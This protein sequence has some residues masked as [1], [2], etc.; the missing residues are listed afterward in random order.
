MCT[1]NYS[2]AQ[3]PLMQWYT[4]DEGLPSS[5]V[6]QLLQDREGFIWCCTGNGIARFD[7]TSF[8]SFTTANGFPDRGAYHMRE[9]KRGRI[10]FIAF[11]GKICY[12]ESGKFHSPVIPLVKNDFVRWMEE[13]PDGRLLFLTHNGN[14]IMQWPDGHFR[15]YPVHSQALFHGRLLSP[16]SLIIASD[17]YF[18]LHLPTGKVTKLDI[19][20]QP[21]RRFIRVLPFT[22]QKVLL[23][24]DNG[25]Y[26]YGHES[27]SFI[28]LSK[29]TMPEPICGLVNDNDDLWIGTYGGALR[30]AGG[31][32]DTTNM[33]YILPGRG[34]TSVIRD[35][36]GNLWFSVY[37]EG[38]C[39]LPRQFTSVYNRENGLMSDRSILRVVKGNDNSVYAFSSLGQLFRLDS[40][41]AM[42]AGNLPIVTS[43]M[44][45][46]TAWESGEGVMVST[47]GVFCHLKNGVLSAPDRDI[48]A[49]LRY[50]PYAPS[51]PGCWVF[52]HLVNNKL[53]AIREYNERTKKDTVRWQAKNNAANENMIC[54]FL[55]PAVER[56][57]YWLG[58]RKGVV[59]LGQNGS[60]WFAADMIPELGTTVTYIANDLSG[61]TWIGTTTAGVFR[62]D[63]KKMIAHYNMDNGLP[64]NY[65]NFLYA[66]NVQ[67]M[68]I[69]TNAGLAWIR[70]DHAV[71][72]T[73]F[74]SPE[75]LPGREAISMCK[76][77]RRVY[78]ATTK[79][80]GSFMDNV[81]Q[82][83]DVFPPV[84]IKNIKIDGQNKDVFT[85]YDLEPGQ[86]NLELSF[87]AI[88]F[89]KGGVMRYRYQL[90]GADT[91]W[92]YTSA[93][94]IQ[95]RSLPP[96]HYTF[97][98]FALSAAGLS[99]KIPAIISFTIPPA[100][101]QTWWFRSLA[102]LMIAAV[103]FSIVFLRARAVQ[104]AN[105]ARQQLLET[106]LQALR[107]QINPHFVFNA[108]NSVQS[109]I[110]S[111]QPEQANEYLV[112]FARM[113]RMI[114][115]GSDKETILLR[116]EIRFLHYYIEMEKLRFDDDFSYRIVID[117]TVDV[118]SFRIPPMILQPI[119]EN[120]FKHGLA[121]KQGEKRLLIHFSGDRNCLY[122]RVEDNGTGRKSRQG[123]DVLDK[124]AL[125]IANVRQRLLLLR[126][127][128][129][130]KEPVCISD[131][132]DGDKPAGVR[133]DLVIG[134]PVKQ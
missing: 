77:G 26:V 5:E 50:C 66:D 133:V 80:V 28:A 63:G 13:T 33:K 22:S 93:G 55:R 46:F 71:P 37:N 65:C 62:F 40:A 120:A 34:V 11:A 73:V 53:A 42:A 111:Q 74:R 7:G 76:V 4:I 115:E 60:M 54:T 69:C 25:V 102:V 90:E 9:D 117:P 121:A 110:F 20:A 44:G 101:W 2:R 47:A 61:K 41:R 88:A 43:T 21:H 86:N 1:A 72:V 16:D 124:T 67:G 82:L 15:S 98:V 119:I 92:N 19:P 68:W 32:M 51:T 8:V 134:R 95:Y 105:R 35:H 83:P 89:R 49:L 87:A 39:M 96:G 14:V 31:Q 91:G 114:S 75:I 38:I 103:L 113:M 100:W 123:E 108:L 36:E 129:D 29:G 57:C 132:Y 10:W 24:A 58:L 130:K 70:P 112:S 79:G 45:T 23:T 12:Y 18:C 116:D 84:Y 81:Q 78:V 128:G 17:F 97:R 59:Y 27:L 126:D 6:Y 85:A 109:F 127:K 56:G 131:L 106:R 64:G 94:H 104:K 118:E 125:G 99:S 122:V 52:P 3:V 30:F 48:H 107:A